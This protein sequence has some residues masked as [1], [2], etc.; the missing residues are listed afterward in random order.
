MQRLFEQRHAINLQM[1]EIEERLQ[2]LDEEIDQREFLDDDH[3]GGGGGRKRR[4][5]LTMMTQQD[6]SQSYSQVESKVKFEVEGDDNT[7]NIGAAGSSQHNSMSFTQHP[8]EYLTDP[9]GDDGEMMLAQHNNDNQSNRLRH[10]DGGNDELRRVSASPP[11]GQGNQY[12]SSNIG[13]NQHNRNKSGGMMGAVHS[14]TPPGLRQ[15]APMSNDQYNSN[16]HQQQQS[17]TNNHTNGGGGV[18]NP[19]GDL[20]TQSDKRNFNDDRTCSGSEHAVSSAGAN[21]GSAA[22][23]TLEKYFVPQQQHH[24]QP[25]PAAVYASAAPHNPYN[26]QNNG[27]MMG[28]MQQNQRHQQ[29][30]SHNNNNAHSNSSKYPWQD[31]MMHHLRNTFHI[32]NFRD[33]QHDII[34]STLSGHDVFVVMRTGGGKSL[35]YQLPAVLEAESD[36]R[37]VTVVISPLISLIRDQEEQMNE[38]LP[39]SALSFTS[40]L[41][42][43]EHNRRWGLVR[44][45]NEGVALIFVTPEKVGKSGRFKGEMEKLNEQGRLGRFVIDE[46]HCACQWGHD[47]RP[48]YTKLGIFKHHFPS[49]PVLAVTATAS[50]RVRD[51]CIQILRLGKNY[52]FFRS[53]ANR[54]NLTYSVKTKPDGKDAI[55]NDMVDFIKTNHSNQAGII[56]TFSR[57]EADNVADQLCDK[58]IIARAYHSDVADARKDNIHRSWMRNET[59]VVV[60]TIAFGLGI[61]KPDVRFVLHHSISK[62]LEAYYQESGRAGRDGQ[63]ADCVLYYSPK[64]VPKML[65]MIHGEAGEPT[66]WHMVRY[67]QAHGDDALCRLAILNILGEA[68]TS[69]AGMERLERLADQCATTKRRNVGSHCQTVTQ[70]VNTLN[71]LGE[72]CTLI[73][74]VAKCKWFRV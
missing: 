55:V 58:G 50:D 14:N 13:S 20:F 32:T 72:D 17:N 10:D 19:F 65:G 39:G 4:Y 56:Y 15:S 9:R 34:N 51:D 69:Q 48:D 57:K 68:D 22:V 49:V 36:K 67:G 38:M 8:E 54:P 5:A 27:Q 11:F 33:H 71:M 42:S 43:A 12:N 47:F 63:P 26:G 74:L 18:S 70:V 30:P 23:N 35:T 60:A 44:D 45:R 2:W 3:D 52:R 73:Q 46:C 37:K 24:H 64:D 21:K 41:G 40:G 53:T 16:H 1:K 28:Q 25:Q 61:N 29:H 66:F 31:R 62:S 7:N 6:Q 59:Q